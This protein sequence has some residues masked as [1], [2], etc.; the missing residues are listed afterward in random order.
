MAY[1]IKITISYVAQAFL[2]LLLVI[3]ALRAIQHGMVDVV[4]GLVFLFICLL[5]V[6]HLHQWRKDL[7]ASRILEKYGD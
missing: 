6:R 2:V 4:I 7:R 1:I 3:Q 5:G